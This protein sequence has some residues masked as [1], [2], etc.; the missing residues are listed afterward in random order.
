MLT[1]VKPN[2]LVFCTTIG[3]FSGEPVNGG[4]HLDLTSDIELPTGD[5]S[6]QNL[7]DAVQPVEST[8]P[9]MHQTS[10]MESIGATSS[11]PLTSH[12]DSQL[13]HGP[14]ARGYPASQQEEAHAV[15][16]NMSYG[17]VYSHAMPPYCPPVTSFQMIDAPVSISSWRG[18]RLQ[19]GYNSET[20]KT[21][22]IF[23]I[24]D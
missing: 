14:P 13:M 3:V 15:Y 17:V 22:T 9:S 18:T 24:Q 11:Q 1:S 19:I 2:L 23:C 4:G 7:Q 6:N 12:A 10:S 5:E 16:S 21:H 8:S 20:V